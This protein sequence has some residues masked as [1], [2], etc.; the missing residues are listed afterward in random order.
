MFAISSFH[1]FN[2]RG[3]TC[4]GDHVQEHLTTFRYDNFR[5]TLVLSESLASSA[6]SLN[7]H[8]VTG[9]SLLRHVDS[10]SYT[11]QN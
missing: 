3:T 10:T 1:S 5:G 11:A 7:C 2:S 4:L 8:I 6:R 9:F